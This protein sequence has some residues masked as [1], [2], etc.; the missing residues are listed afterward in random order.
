MKILWRTLHWIGLIDSL[1]G[2]LKGKSFC[3]GECRLGIYGGG[4]Y[5]YNDAFSYE[6]YFEE[7]NTIALQNYYMDIFIKKQ[8]FIHEILC[9]HLHKRQI[10]ENW[11]FQKFRAWLSGRRRIFR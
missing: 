1:Y 6:F 8:I 5:P 3:M 4:D 7:N 2:I 11:N 10:E 9:G